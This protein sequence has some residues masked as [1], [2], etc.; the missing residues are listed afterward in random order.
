MYNRVMRNN[1]IALA[2]PPCSGKSIVGEILASSLEAD[3]ID[4]DSRIEHETGHSIEWI[5]SQCGE[6]S[7]RAAEKRILEKVI[8]SALCLTVVALGGGALLS[9]DCR[10]LAEE[11]TFLFTLSASSDTLIERNNGNRP[12]AA[13]SDMMRK[14]ITRREEHYSSLSNPVCTEDLSP[15]QVAEI[16]RRAVLLQLSL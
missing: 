11:N 9:S 1:I 12:L 10:K 7:F 15:E 13:N 3:F 14:L 4:L 8:S 5:F 16:I 6:E 2:G